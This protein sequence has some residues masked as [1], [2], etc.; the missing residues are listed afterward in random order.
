MEKQENPNPPIS[1]EQRFFQFLIQEKQG[2]LEQLNSLF[3]VSELV[4][5]SQYIYQFEIVGYIKVRR[6]SVIIHPF[7]F[8]KFLEEPLDYLIRYFEFKKFLK[9]PKNSWMLTHQGWKTWKHFYKEPNFFESLRGY[10]RYY[11]YGA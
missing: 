10:Y 11:V 9:L 7:I 2:T 1:E 4:R 3:P 5:E 6:G 8:Q